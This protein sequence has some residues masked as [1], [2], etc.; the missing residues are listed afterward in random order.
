MKHFT[1]TIITLGFIINFLMLQAQPQSITLTFAAR[2]Y[3]APVATDSILV[4]NINRNCDTV[5]YAPDTTLVLDYTVGLSEMIKPDK[6]FR[7]YQNYPNPVVNG[8][9]FIDVRLPEKSQLVLKVYDMQGMAV[10]GYSGTLPS[11][12]HTFAFYP[13]K[14]GNYLLTAIAGE[15]YQ[16]VK[17]INYGAGKNHSSRLVH[18]SYKKGSSGLKTA[19]SSKGFW[20]EPGDTLRYVG[21][22]KTPQDIN[23]S[24]VLESAPEV[25]ST[26]TFHIIEG[27]PCTGIEAVKYM[28]H[29]YPTVQIKNQCWL[30]EN[31]NVGTMIS[32]DTNMTDNG[33]L[34][35]YCYDN[36]PANCE[37]YGG[38]YQWN[39]MMQYTNTEGGQGICPQG[40]HVATKSEWDILSYQQGSIVFK[41]TGTYHWLPGNLGTNSS[42]FT[43]LPGGTKHYYSGEFWLLHAN[44]VFY[45]SSEL[46]PPSWGVWFKEFLY[47]NASDSG[48]IYKNEGLSVRCIKDEN[49]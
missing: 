32:G 37:V 33:I 27:V 19:E 1:K 16:S 11:G 10:T 47:S 13:E 17:I 48:N 43:A 9:T 44:A 35:K 39:E 23:G 25:N 22:A 18:H 49:K 34:E 38:L 31:L 15:K 14:R 42:G 29:L 2:Y 8:K 40:W 30:K 41:E 24:D 5:L 20:F 36:D 6:A 46:A 4:K 12:T 26:F 45:T 3:G 7:V 21:Y 28:G